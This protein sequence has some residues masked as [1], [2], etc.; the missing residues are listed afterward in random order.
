MLHNK[1]RGIN[2]TRVEHR[3]QWRCQSWVT[4]ARGPPWSLWM[5]ANF[6][7]LTPDDVHF[8]MN[9]SPR[10]SEPVRHALV[11]LLEQ[12]SVDATDRALFKCPDVK[13]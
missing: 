12:N 5:H 8:W 11:T 1:T 2:I 7:D 3:A 6:A 13:H 9:L 4:G 10:T